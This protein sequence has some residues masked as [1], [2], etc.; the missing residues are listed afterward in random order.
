MRSLQ[1]CAALV[2][3]LACCHANAGQAQAEMTLPS[4]VEGSPPLRVSVAAERA[5]LDRGDR[6]R[7]EDA[8]LARYPLYQRG[9][10][11]PA[12]VLLV[13]RGPHWLYVTLSEAGHAGACFTAVFAADRFDFTAA[14]LAKYRPRATPPED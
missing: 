5:V 12:Q 13:R 14:W 11:A 10:W 9:G 4:C 7:F 8:A 2:L 6:Q 1:P 3:G